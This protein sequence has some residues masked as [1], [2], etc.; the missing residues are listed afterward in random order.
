MPTGLSPS[1]TIGADTGF[2]PPSWSSGKPALTGFTTDSATP[3]CQR[4]IGRSNASHPDLNSLPE[5]S[6]SSCLSSR[7]ELILRLLVA[8]H[9]PLAKSHLLRYRAAKSW[10]RCETQVLEFGMRNAEFGFGSGGLSGLA[11]AAAARSRIAPTLESV[12]TT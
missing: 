6:G 8:R 12:E 2:T 5:P 7:P 1:P 4:I 10:C 11:S 9:A 3:A